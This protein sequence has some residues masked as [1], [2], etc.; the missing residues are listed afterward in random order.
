MI[1]VDE[2]KKE[3]IDKLHTSKVFANFI[4]ENKEIDSDD[5]YGFASEVIEEL[6]GKLGHKNF[7]SISHA[8]PWMTER[9][10]ILRQLLRENGVKITTKPVEVRE[11]L[12]YAEWNNRYQE[13][14]K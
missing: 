12:S 3:I 10:N 2:T 9:Q 13:S 5:F 11:K 14:E 6:Y 4:K 1:V 8:M 7:R